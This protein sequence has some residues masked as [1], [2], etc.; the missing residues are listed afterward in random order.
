MLGTGSGAVIFRPFGCVLVAG[1]GG[2]GFVRA[3]DRAGK[4]QYE[5]GR[6]QQDHQQGT[7]L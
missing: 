5:T 6:E 7:G 2:M 1:C 3:F 4:D